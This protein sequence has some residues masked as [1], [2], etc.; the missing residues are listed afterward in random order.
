MTS[1]LLGLAY[2]AYGDAG[3]PAA[4]AAEA[5]VVFESPST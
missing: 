3:E 1:V 2:F 4:S 5:V